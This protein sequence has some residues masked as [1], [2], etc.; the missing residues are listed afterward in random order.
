MSKFTDMTV[1]ELKDET[2]K[3]GLTL[4]Y[5]GHKFNKAELVE[6]L[7]QY[8]EV[9]GETEQTFVELDSEAEENEVWVQSGNLPEH[10]EEQPEPNMED[11]YDAWKKVPGKISEKKHFFDIKFAETLDEIE[12]KY[13]KPKPQF[14]FDNN[15]NIGS[16]VVF[17]CYV[18]ANNGNIYKKLRT[19]KVVAVNRKK[20]LVRVQTFLGD[21]K[22]LPFEELLFI[23][24]D[25][26]LD[27][28]TDIK[29]YLRKQ[30]TE[31]GRK[32]LNER[33]N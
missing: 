16:F 13:R 22:E 24:K 6:R 5:K 21:E 17:V 20:E 31:N 26:E 32:L 4:E 8:H 14:V 28:P 30:R 18:E 19:A 11:D 2:R 25:K 12:E 27:Y 15:L 3:A 33:F 23:K 29:K 1:K 9:V 10:E 7:E